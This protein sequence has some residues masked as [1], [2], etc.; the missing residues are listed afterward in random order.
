ML[1]RIRSASS[2]LEAALQSGKKDTASDLSRLPAVSYLYILGSGGHTGE[3][4]DLIK[5]SFKPSKNAHRRYIISRGDTTSVVAKRSLEDLIRKKCP[6]GRA[7]TH[8]SILVTRVR[9]VGDPYYLLPITA[10]RSGLDV[11]FALTSSPAPRAAQPSAGDFKYPHVIVT[12]G[13]GTGFIVGLVAF[14]LKVLWLAPQNR[15]KVIY[16]ESWARTCNLG[17]TGKL[18][19]KVPL[20]HLFAVQNDQLSQVVGRPN[21]GNISA[22]YAALPIPQ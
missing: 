3:M 18:F 8:D 10:L 4:I 11:L 12:N 5:L 1:K 9:D 13:P 16:I 6:D 15:L 22:R 20:A 7:G 17:V 2:K 14:L 21:M 19:H